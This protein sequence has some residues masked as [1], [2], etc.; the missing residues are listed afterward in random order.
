[1]NGSEFST[2]RLASQST[3]TALRDEYN[4]KLCSNWNVSHLF[5]NNWRTLEIIANSLEQNKHRY[6]QEHPLLKPL[7]NHLEPIKLQQERMRDLRKIA[8]IL[9]ANESKM[10]RK[11]AFDS[12][13]CE[14]LDSRGLSRVADE[15]YFEGARS[16][17]IMHS[18]A[19]L[20]S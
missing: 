19:Q 17:T 6:S 9:D 11:P 4:R 10:G 7:L 13:I 1:M 12:S 8:H 16:S 20:V 5:H 3:I 14:S 18:L 15:L 2:L